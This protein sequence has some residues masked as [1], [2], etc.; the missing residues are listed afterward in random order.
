M[1]NEVK[2]LN[3]MVIMSDRLVDFAKFI[4]QIQQEL[5]ELRT[6]HHNLNDRLVLLEQKPL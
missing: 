6:L 3:R 2:I 5:A 4:V 1:S